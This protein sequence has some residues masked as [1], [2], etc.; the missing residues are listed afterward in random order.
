MALAV[1]AYGSLVSAQSAS[2]TLGRPVEAV[3][4]VR[5]EGWERRWTLARDNHASEKR[6]RRPDGS[7]PSF[8]LGLNLEP[9]AAAAGPNGALIEVSEAEL[10]RLDLREIRYRRLEVSDAIRKPDGTAHDFDAV[11]AYRARPEHHRQEPPRD[12]I[13][14]ASYPRTIEAAFAS[15]GEA[16]L[17]TYRETTPAPPVEVVEAVLVEDRIP[18]GNPREW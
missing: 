10:E 17:A 12:A 15:H 1:F 7:V 11:L 13:V 4:L 18:P 2:L 16:A 3:E 5:L 14:I 6:F 8:C 9:A